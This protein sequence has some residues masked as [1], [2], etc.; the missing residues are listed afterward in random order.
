M[1]STVRSAVPDTPRKMLTMQ[2]EALRKPLAEGA[3]KAA[4][5]RAIERALKASDITK[6]AAAY[7][8]G[9]GDNQSPVTRWISGAETPQFAKLWT[10][11]DRFRQELVIALAD[12]CE[13]GVT[14]ETTIRISRRKAVNA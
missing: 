10:L 5:G 12:E 3:F 13:M 11:G 8:M 7:D 2:G 6:Q 9:Y 4:I 14:L 1:R